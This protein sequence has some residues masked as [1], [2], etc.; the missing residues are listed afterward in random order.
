ML[1]CSHVR[2]VNVLLIIFHIVYGTTQVVEMDQSEQIQRLTEAI[3]NMRQELDKFKGSFMIAMLLVMLVLPT[4]VQWLMMLQV[5]VPSMR[6]SILSQPVGDADRKATSR[7]DA[8]S[9][10]TIADDMPLHIESQRII[11]L[12][13]ILTGHITLGTANEPR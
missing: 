11:I 2:V 1:S 7:R 12:I 10:L 6:R 3:A 4:T 13:L 8:W 9:D 5:I